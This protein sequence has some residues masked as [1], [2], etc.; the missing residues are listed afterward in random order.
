VNNTGNLPG[1]QISYDIEKYRNGSNA[2]GF[3]IQLYY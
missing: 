1:L 3:R 2:A